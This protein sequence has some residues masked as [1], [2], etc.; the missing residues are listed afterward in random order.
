[1]M[2]KKTTQYQYEH[3]TTAQRNT[4]LTSLWQALLISQRFPVC[5]DNFTTEAAR[6]NQPTTTW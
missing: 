2:R 1:M 3:F 6:Y 4:N 5:N